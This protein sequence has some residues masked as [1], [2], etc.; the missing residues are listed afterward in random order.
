MS[1]S[2]VQRVGIVH[3]SLYDEEQFFGV[4]FT[5]SVFSGFLDHVIDNFLQVDFYAALCV[6][7][8]VEDTALR[9]VLVKSRK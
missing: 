4:I 2:V 7:L 6:G 1:V 8:C 9:V 5:H 3:L